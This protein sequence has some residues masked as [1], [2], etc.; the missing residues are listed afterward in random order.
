V[1]SADT[2]VLLRLLLDDDA[3]QQAQAEAFLRRHRELYVAQVA[4]AEMVWVLSSGKRYSREQVA[5]VIEQLLEVASIRIEG[6]PAVHSA[7]ARFRA[8][9]A[10]FADCLILE[11]ARAAGALPLATFDAQLGKIE[12]TQRLGKKRG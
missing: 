1:A 12:G 5:R 10:D 2:N 6:A 8:S 4:L 9:H 7:V 11:N 3:E